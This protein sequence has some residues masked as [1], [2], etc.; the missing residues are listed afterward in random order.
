MRR[1]FDWSLLKDLLLTIEGGSFSQAAQRLGVSQST[2]GR[3]VAELERELGVQLFE[4]VGRR[5]IPTETARRLA[6]EARG[7]SERID[8]MVR[9][10]ETERTE[11]SGILRISASH[12]TALHVLPPI[13]SGL[14]SRHPRL[15]IEVSASGFSEDLQRR[16]AD[17]A[18]RHVRPHQPDLIARKLGEIEIGAYAS[19]AYLRS[20]GT[21]KTI[22]DLTK[23]RLIV[24]DQDKV[25]HQAASQCGYEL[26]ASQISLA[27][28]F[29][30]MHLAAARAGVGIGFF[31]RAT[32]LADSE[33]VE[34]MAVLK[35]EPMPVW[36]AAHRGLIDSKRVRVV[37]DELAAGIRLYLSE[38]NVV[39]RRDDSSEDFPPP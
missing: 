4:R 36:L 24:G 3:R 32:A 39:S 35:I 37:F 21:P 16:E 7:V 10:T 29:F 20:Y 33:L 28:D 11:P 8:A 14:V 15:T 12:F 30:P 34:I 6:E 19:R 2:V 1:S 17:V 31:N 13:V 18:V 27:T 5:L 38:R 23:H 22:A 9:L 25:V 26:S